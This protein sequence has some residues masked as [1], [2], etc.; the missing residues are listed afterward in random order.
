MI[1]EGSCHCGDISLRF[2]TEHEPAALP[3]TICGCT[4]C[5]KHRPRF[6]NDPTGS[7]AITYKDEACLSRYRFALRLADFLVCRTCGVFACTFLNQR[8]CINLEVLKRSLEFS[9]APARFT[10]YNSETI[11]TRRARWMKEWTPAMLQ[12]R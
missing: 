4:F 1:L 5:I 6:T 12:P 10:A 9:A 8:A 11:D 3:V 2:E 7:L